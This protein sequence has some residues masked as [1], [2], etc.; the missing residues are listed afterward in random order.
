MSALQSCKK[1]LWKSVKMCNK[2]K[3]LRNTAAATY[4]AH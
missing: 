3:K 2:G 1:L 4:F